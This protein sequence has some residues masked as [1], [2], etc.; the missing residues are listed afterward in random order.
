MT[1]PDEICRGKLAPNVKGKYVLFGLSEA[2]IIS[3]CYETR[4]H[5]K[6]LMDGL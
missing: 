5:Y 2:E 3:G 1:C 4:K 6:K